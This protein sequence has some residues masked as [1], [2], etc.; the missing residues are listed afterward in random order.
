MK[1][2]RCDLPHICSV[3]SSDDG[4]SPALDCRL[5]LSDARRRMSPARY[6]QSNLGLRKVKHGNVPANVHLSVS[7]TEPTRSPCTESSSPFVCWK[8]EQPR[9]Q[10]S[11]RRE[12]LL[13]YIKS[14]AT[15]PPSGLP[16]KPA[17]HLP[18]GYDH[19]SAEDQ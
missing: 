8:S 14:F 5:G 6:C 11:G 18:S 13:N 12:A 9:K 1:W 4:T 19:A 16:K 10:A 7:H 17:Q 15:T 2:D 3:L